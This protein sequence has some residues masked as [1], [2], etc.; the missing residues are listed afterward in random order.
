MKNK[1]LIILFT[2]L[3]ITSFAQIGVKGGINLSNIAADRELIDEKQ[4]KVGWQVGFMA[5]MKAN[6]WLALQPELILIQKGADYSYISSDIEAK[7]LYVE[8]PIMAVFNPLGG[9]LNIHIGPQFSFL[10][11][12]EYEYR[13]DILGTEGVTDD[14]RNNYE[15]FDFGMGI[16]AGLNLG[17][18]LIEIRYTQGFMDV[19]KKQFIQNVE[20]GTDAKHFNLQ[21]SVGFFF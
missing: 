19:E 8:V 15:T 13:N 7:M 14:D 9:P 5:K 10:A 16:G 21:G 6:E 11:D 17:N 4:T 18:A 12:V 2:F 20:F 1:F 3:A